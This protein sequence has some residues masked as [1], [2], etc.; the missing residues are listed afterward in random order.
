MTN[1]FSPTP[2]ATLDNGYNNPNVSEVFIPSCGIEDVDVSL[3]NLFDK[4]LRFYAIGNE[5]IKEA[6]Q[7]KVPV[8]FAGGEK[9]AIL[10]KGK[11]L[12]DKAGS[13]ILPLITIVR[14]GVEQN[15]TQDI[16]GRG[17]NQQTGQLSIRRKLDTSDRAYQNL[18]N[19]LYI[20]N[21]KNLAV[22]PKDKSNIN[23]LTS[24][25]G[26]IGD[27]RNDPNVL[28]GALMVPNKL[29]NVYET[30]TIPSP[31]F[32]SAKY[33]ITFWSQYTHHMNGMLEIFMSSLLPQG[34]S[35]KLQTNKGYWF[36]AQVEEVFQ[37]ENNFDDMSQ[38]E[39]LIK[40]KITI[41]VPAYLLASNTPGT[42][43]PV[44][45]YISSPTVTF[46]ADVESY[47]GVKT[48]KD[49]TEYPFLGSDD[50]TLPTQLKGRPERED[51]RDDGIGPLGTQ[52]GANSD[53]ALNSFRRGTQQ[54]S[55][56]RIGNKLVKT[57]TI[58]G[59]NGEKIYKGY[60]FGELEIIIDE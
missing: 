5:S 26:E 57:Q 37:Q 38:Q 13:L 52:T 40:Q 29:K 28:N 33:E 36:V 54:T 44:R 41:N 30:L 10:K 12:R 60:N 50:P 7:K 27:L 8:I 9:W 35:F 31:Q 21:Q 20:L 19:R 22:N 24:D 18:I 59:A 47:L 14:T 32:F 53:P 11:P 56:T 43:I 4:E 15:V 1:R 48:Q 55:Y 49:Q 23:Q 58:S 2:P 25:I 45:R 3:F 39:R 51:A 16:T 46:T 42:P 17:I 6:N 34:R